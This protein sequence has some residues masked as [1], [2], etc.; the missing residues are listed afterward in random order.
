MTERAKIVEAMTVVRYARYQEATEGAMSVTE[1]DAVDAWWREHGLALKEAVTA[2]RVAEVARLRE[3]LEAAQKETIVAWEAAE[4]LDAKVKSLAP[5]GTCGC[6]S[7]RLGDVCLHH[8]PRVKE[9]EATLAALRTVVREAATELE[10]LYK[11]I[12]PTDD[13]KLLDRLRAA[14]AEG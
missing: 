4:A 7:D 9:L 13:W 3:Q 6:S 8:S 2:Y 14:A 5:H 11:H 10:Q 12:E 1:Q